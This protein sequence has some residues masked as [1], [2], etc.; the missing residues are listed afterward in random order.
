MISAGAIGVTG[1]NGKTSVGGGVRIVS[2]AVRRPVHQ[3]AGI[4]QMLRTVTPLGPLIAGIEFNAEE[5][6]NLAKHAIFHDA[7][8]HAVR[9]GDAN[10]A[11]QRHRPFDLETSAR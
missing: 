5:V 10:A 6:A 1:R 7:G 2:D 9:I 3:P 4:E 11:A 8:E